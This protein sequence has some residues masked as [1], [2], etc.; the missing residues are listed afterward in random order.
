MSKVA[1]E[2]SHPEKAQGSGKDPLQ[3]RMFCDSV[4]DDS[5]AMDHWALFHDEVL[6]VSFRLIHF[7]K[8]HQSKFGLLVPKQLIQ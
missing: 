2:N 5:Q 7:L 3:L 6:S 4:T 1:Q 8:E